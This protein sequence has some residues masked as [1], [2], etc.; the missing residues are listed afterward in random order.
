MKIYPIDIN[1]LYMMQLQG[2]RWLRIPPHMVGIFLNAGAVVR[3][4]SSVDR[5]VTLLLARHVHTQAAND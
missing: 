4:F 2:S 5:G 1:A 3:E